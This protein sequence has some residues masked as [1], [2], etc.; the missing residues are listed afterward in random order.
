MLNAPVGI[1]LWP[2]VCFTPTHTEVLET[3]PGVPTQ[4]LARERWLRFQD[5]ISS[6]WHGFPWHPCVAHSCPSLHC[7]VMACW[8]WPALVLISL[9]FRLGMLVW[10]IKE[11]I[12]FFLLHQYAYFTSVCSS[13]FHFWANYAFKDGPV[14]DWP[15]VQGVF[16]CLCP[17]KL[18]WAPASPW[19]YTEQAVWKMD[20][21]I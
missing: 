2:T 7:W 9:N 4:R 15:S 13:H 17:K 6:G 8:T 12:Y 10:E 5:Y 19:S 20:G 21:W 11:N 1:I 16:F 18:R 14:M 3:H